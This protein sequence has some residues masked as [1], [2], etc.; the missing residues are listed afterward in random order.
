MKSVHSNPR[1]GFIIAAMT[2]AAIPGHA[3]GQAPAGQPKTAEA[4]VP[5]T[6]EEHFAAAKRYEE[7]AK[8]YR[9]E[10]EAHRKMFSAVAPPIKLGTEDPGVAKMRKH[11][12]DYIQKADA[13]AQEADSFAQFHRMLGK[14][15]QGK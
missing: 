5:Q 10:A 8:E 9:A 11:C 14:E 1:R 12:E 2:A 6:P 15:M 13:L 4:K 3:F 7:K